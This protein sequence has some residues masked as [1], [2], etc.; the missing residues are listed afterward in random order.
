MTTLTSCFTCTVPY[1]VTDIV[2][3]FPQ[4]G[5]ILT[6]QHPST[7]FFLTLH[8]SNATIHDKK[9]Q[10]E[11]NILGMKSVPN[12]ETCFLSI[13]TQTKVYLFQVNTNHSF[14]L[15]YFSDTAPNPTGAMSLVRDS[16]EWIFVHPS[17]LKSSLI[18]RRK[19]SVPIMLENIHSQSISKIECSLNH[20]TLFIATV[21]RSGRNVRVWVSSGNSAE[22]RAEFRRGASSA[23]PMFLSFSPDACFVGLSSSKSSVHLFSLVD[24]SH[25]VIKLSSFVSSPWLDS[26][27][28][29]LWRE[30][31]LVLG[32]END[33]KDKVMLLEWEEN[34][35]REVGLIE[36]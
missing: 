11:G 6:V 8:P 30:G 29:L 27:S 4:C 35:C 22:K 34:T 20:N 9:L 33:R 5:A 21:S 28:K 12:S 17:I 13:S 36:L 2:P 18:I 3:T 1:I 7:V 16:H 31:K 10:L 26:G 32:V 25:Q 23:S 14:S 24:H 15:V 19:S